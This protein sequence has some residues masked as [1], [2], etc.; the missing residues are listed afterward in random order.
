MNTWLQTVV[1]EC[2]SCISMCF[3]DRRDS[4]R[5]DMSVRESGVMRF[6]QAK[7]L[8]TVLYKNLFTLKFRNNTGPSD[9]L[10]ITYRN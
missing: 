5:V 9:V 10:L 2:S 3:S 8:G 4:D 6:E 7:W 1:D